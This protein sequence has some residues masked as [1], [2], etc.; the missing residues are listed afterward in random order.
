MRIALITIRG[1]AAAAKAELAELGLQAE[2]KGSNWCLAEADEQQLQL[3]R[4]RSQTAVRVLEL[5]AT[6][7]ALEPLAEVIK[8]LPPSELSFSL[9]SDAEDRQFIEEEYGGQIKDVTGAPVELSK[10]QRRYFIHE[11]DGEY[12]FGIDCFDNLG[13]RHYKII[14][15][16]SSLAGPVAACV[17]R[18]SGWSPKEDLLV[19]PCGT[20]ELAIE[21][22]LWAAGKSPRAYEL[23]EM[24]ERQPPCTIIAAD[25]KLPMV[26]ST[27]KNAKVAGVA[28]FIRFSR[29]D[30]EWLDTKHD[31]RS[32]KHIVGLLP[33]L[34]VFKKLAKEIFYQLDFIL[35]QSGTASFLC[36]NDASAESLEASADGY[37][38]SRTYIWSGKHSYTLVKLTK[39]KKQKQVKPS[40]T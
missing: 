16:T 28:K 12:L 21:A 32:V 5:L 31:E 39:Q 18:E 20:G 17:L 7:S 25:S 10:P 24:S 2:V 19:W 27:E 38:V 15:G 13:K 29:Q 14:A 33:N 6:T 23:Q 9:R 30:A 11:T 36:V 40:A 3:L 35:K 37:D 22:A 8:A 34:A 26:R 4:V 1:G